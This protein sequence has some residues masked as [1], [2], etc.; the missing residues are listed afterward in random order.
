MRQPSY[1]PPTSLILNNPLSNAKEEGKEENTSQNSNLTSSNHDAANS[2]DD[3]HGPS[4]VSSDVNVTSL[5][6]ESCV[7]CEG[8]LVTWCLG[9]LLFDWLYMAALVINVLVLGTVPCCCY[10]GVDA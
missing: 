2:T 3:M 7:D 8:E 6:E 5:E 4:A 10:V 1:V 9:L